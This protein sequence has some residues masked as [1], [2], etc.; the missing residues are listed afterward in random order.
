[1]GEV[2][3]SS[4]LEVKKLEYVNF[5]NFLNPRRRRRGSKGKPTSRSGSPPE[6]HPRLKPQLHREK[7]ALPGGRAAF[8]QNG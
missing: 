2:T 4:M 8:L 7:A 1:L 6:D 5:R 3:K